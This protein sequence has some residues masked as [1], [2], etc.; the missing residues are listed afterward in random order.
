MRILFIASLLMTVLAGLTF[1]CPVMGEPFHWGA[2]NVLIWMVGS[3]ALGIAAVIIGDQALRA[4]AIFFF[5]VNTFFGI[6]LLFFALL[7]G[8]PLGLVSIET[9]R[10]I[11][12]IIA[13]TFLLMAA[14]QRF[15]WKNAG[16]NDPML[17]AFTR[18]AGG[19]LMVVI[20]ATA[21][22]PAIFVA[23]GWNAARSD[24]AEHQARAAQLRESGRG[25]ANLGGKERL[26]ILL[27][28]A[29]PNFLSH[30]G[31]DSLT[32]CAHNRTLTLTAAWHF[33]GKR[34]DY[35]FRK[36]RRAG[37]ALGM[38]SRLSKE[39]ILTL[40]LDILYMGQVS[41]Q[42]AGSIRGVF[43]ASEIFFGKEPARLSRP[44]YVSL[45]AIMT[46]G[47][48]LSLYRDQHRLDEQVLK[49]E[50]LLAGKCDAS[51]AGDL[52]LYQ[53]GSHHFKDATEDVGS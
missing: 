15:V 49:I 23:S 45:I 5:G 13:V 27:Q 47:G 26:E 6:L 14:A 29:D 4:A 30:N 24:A 35:D 34:G 41:L 2:S 42:D 19:G 20:V 10:E 53:C 37:Y 18:R 16:R 51:Y 36:F 12:T 52:G 31:M 25:V 9:G 38:E 22:V 39:E 40:Y 28:V 46:S 50:R 3:I 7:G 8:I 17:I 44:E 32:P 1:W 48:R 21:S 33:E 11:T 43:A